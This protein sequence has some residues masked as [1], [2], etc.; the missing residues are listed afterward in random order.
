MDLIVRQDER[1]YFADKLTRF[2]LAKTYLGITELELRR[3]KF[4][5]ELIKDLEEKY[6]K[7]KREVG[8]AKE[9]VVREKMR[10]I[11]GID[12]KPYRRGEVEFDG[13]AF[14]DKVYVLEVSG[15]TSLRYIGM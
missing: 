2:W 7:M 12:F 5:E 8:V 13:V 10:E 15:G 1:Y 6:L 4:L 11:F 14:G 3:E 9:A